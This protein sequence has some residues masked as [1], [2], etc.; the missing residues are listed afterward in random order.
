RKGYA[1][2]H[3][4][5]DYRYQFPR[6]DPALPEVFVYTEKMSYD[7]GETV[8]FHGSTTARTWSIQ[9]YSD[10]HK[11]Q[12][13][14]EAFELPGSFTKTSETA[15]MD[16]CDW[17]VLYRWKIPDDARSGFY[18]VVSTCLRPD[19]ERFVQHHFVVV[20]PTRKTRSGRI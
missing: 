19:G 8:E 6:E 14:D 18:R 17:P 10:G 12:M 7:P 20:R 15:F 5:S 2:E 1:D 9:I 13:R 16:G 4:L 11:P 3:F